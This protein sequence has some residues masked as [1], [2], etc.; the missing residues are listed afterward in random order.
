MKT[1]PQCS[2]VYTD[3]NLNFCLVDGTQLAI[4]P[5]MASEETVVIPPPRSTVA[6][7]SKVLMWIGLAVIAIFAIVIVLGGLIFFRYYR[8]TESL[9]AARPANSNIAVSPTPVPKLKPSP[10]PSPAGTAVPGASPKPESTKKDDSSEDISPIAW[11]T[12]ANGFTGEPGKKYKFECPENGQAGVVWGSDVYTD[13]SSICTAA[14]HVG[15]FSLEDGGTVELEFR[16][17]RAI[18]G[19]TVRNGIKSATAGEYSRSFV[20]RSGD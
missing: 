12:A 10:A 18:Y 11:D 13:Y 6:T 8:E 20:V 9:R 14:V 7:K 17:G 16:P 15:L 19:S 1:C 2:R 4:A 3:D 5:D